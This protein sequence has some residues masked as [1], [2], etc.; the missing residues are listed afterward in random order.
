M[1]R[2]PIETNSR[3]SL[4]IAADEK[5]LLMRAVSLRRTNL[6][7]FVIRPA[8][9]AARA[10][11]DQAER[12]PLSERDSRSVLALLEHPPAPNARLM[13]AAQALPKPE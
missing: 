9:E 1:P 6:T 13:A 3:M 8:I 11:I 12:M 10:V 5:A 4:R 2:V 7:E